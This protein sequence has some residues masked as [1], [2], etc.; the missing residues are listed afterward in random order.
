M[1]ARVLVSASASASVCLYV[2]VDIFFVLGVASYQDKELVKIAVEA[3]AKAI[4]FASQDM[5]ADRDVALAALQSEAGASEVLAL[6]GKNL[7]VCILF[8]LNLKVC[9]LFLFSFEASVSLPV[10]PVRGVPGRRMLK[11][12]GMARLGAAWLE[13]G[14][15][16]HRSVPR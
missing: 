4:K 6:V 3:N 15:A 11:R 10:V 9:I 14:Q 8:L 16:Q 2:C 1:C 7:K 12:N 5:K 13:M